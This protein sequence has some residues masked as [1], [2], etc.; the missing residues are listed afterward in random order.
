MFIICNPLKN[1][2]VKQILS[3]HCS[4]GWIAEGLPSSATLSLGSVFSSWLYWLAEWVCPAN[5]GMHTGKREGD[6]FR[7]YPRTNGSPNFGIRSRMFSH[8]KQSCCRLKQ[9]HRETPLFALCSCER[10]NQGYGLW[11]GCRGNRRTEI[12]VAFMA[13]GCRVGH[14]ER[15]GHQGWVVAG[16]ILPLHCKKKM[17][18]GG[19]T[20]V[21]SSLG[22]W[23]GQVWN[24]WT[25]SVKLVPTV[26]CF[27]ANG[28]GSGSLS[29][30]FSTILVLACLLSTEMAVTPK[31]SFVSS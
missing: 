14:R 8:F 27:M 11:R 31:P 10:G 3:Y 2:P 7:L 19:G 24:S 15:R 5:A 18:A 17:E 12:F 25:N 16:F 28:I 23:E 1:V 22:N 29:T 30:S 20:D 13:G 26:S 6:I 9:L 21:R 4:C